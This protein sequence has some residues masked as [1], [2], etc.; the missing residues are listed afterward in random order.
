MIFQYENQLHDYLD[1]MRLQKANAR[2]NRVVQ[3]LIVLLAA[4]C[5]VYMNLA[6]LRMSFDRNDTVAYG[7]ALVVMVLM[8]AVY[9]PKI[10]P[11]LVYPILERLDLLPLDSVGHRE[12]EVQ[13]RYLCFRHWGTEVRV[14]YEGLM[15]VNHNDKTILFYLE[16][17]T[18]ESVPLRVV[19]ATK[20]E[21][22]AFLEMIQQ[23][24]R[25]ANARKNK[26]E[27]PQWLENPQ[28][29]MTCQVDRESI[30]VSTLREIKTRR[31]NWYK[32]FFSVVFVGVLLLS[33]V[34]GIYGLI[35]REQLSAALQT[36]L[37][38]FYIL[39]LPGCLIAAVLS[40]RPNFLVKWT[41]DQSLRAG[42]YPTGYLGSRKVEW[43]AEC[44]A[45][46][47]GYFGLKIQWDWVGAVRDDGINLYFYQGD[48]M[49]LF[50]PR[51]E[52]SSAFMD[53][54]AEKYSI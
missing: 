20:E 43:D 51:K 8:L 46:R 25:K 50:L 54:L 28:L 47:Y 39:E 14:A 7:V 13:D 24:A 21:C 9:S 23:K 42:N 40:Y 38:V 34:G 10:I 44:L 33:I 32:R 29:T 18:V 52:L 48:T 41:L 49:F 19:G 12:L 3:H 35:Y 11:S 15:R 37:T 4:G 22:T 2:S 30:V 5:L 26:T 1:A 27:L 36:Y 31:R 16:N 53:M 17:G 45:F 6:T